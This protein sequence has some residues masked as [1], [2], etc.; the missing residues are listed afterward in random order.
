MDIYRAL[1]LLELN[2]GHIYRDDVAI[3]RWKDDS[4]EDFLRCRTTLEIGDL[5]AIDWRHSMKMEREK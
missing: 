4:W 2:G 5:T 1:R 3:Y